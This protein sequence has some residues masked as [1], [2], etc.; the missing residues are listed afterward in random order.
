MNMTVIEKRNNFLG[1]KGCLH[2]ERCR[3]IV[4]NVPHLDEFSV[5]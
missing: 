1:T 5:W 2:R 4:D 3:L